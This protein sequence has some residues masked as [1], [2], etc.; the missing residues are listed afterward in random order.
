MTIRF[1]R[2]LVALFMMA[3]CAASVAASAAESNAR[4]DA[5]TAALLTEVRRTFKL[6]GKPV[7]PEIFR[8]FGDGNLADSG[9]IWVTV[10]IAGAIGSNQY[11]DDIKEDGG[12][13]VQKKS[14]TKPE[15]YQRTAYTFIGS[16]ANG[17]LVVVA[18]FNSGGSGFFTTLHI[19]DLAAARAYDLDGRLYRRINLTS[20]RRVPLGDRWDGEVTI[21]RNSV[22]VVTTRSGPADD[23]GARRTMTIEAQRP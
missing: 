7:P 17:L 12:W 6:D 8:D 2:A 14:V 9:D 22:H 11:D 15:D 3:W 23:S 1:V 5:A 18:T 4:P 13:V 10:N 21:A 16:T 19:L 20:L